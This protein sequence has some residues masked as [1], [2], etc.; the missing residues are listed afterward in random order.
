MCS[1]FS[2]GDKEFPAESQP[3]VFNFGELNSFFATH[4]WKAIT[5]EQWLDILDAEQMPVTAAFESASLDFATILQLP[6]APAPTEPL[7][8]TW[9]LLED[10]SWTRTV[11]NPEDEVATILSPA[12]TAAAAAATAADA[13][14]KVQA[15]WRGFS[16][17]VRQV[18]PRLRI[19]SVWM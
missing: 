1:A 18:L 16:T 7:K 14:T 11:F 17:R 6:S 4:S 5:A 8:V 3:L 12:L 10:G 13:A 9:A 19:T 2:W 15:V